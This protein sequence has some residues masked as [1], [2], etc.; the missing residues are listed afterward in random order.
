MT[1]LPLIDTRLLGKPKVYTGAKA[2]WHQWKYVFL[3]YVGAVDQRLLSALELAEQQDSA[4]DFVNFGDTAQQQA[5]TMSYILSQM[6]QG[7]PLQL[8]MNSGHNGLE[9]WRQLVRQEEPVSGASQVATLS[10]ILSTKFSGKGTSFVEEMQKFEGALQRYEAQFNEPLPDALHQA[11]LKSN[12][13]GSIKNQVDMTTF[14]NATVLKDALVQY[15]QV[16]L[17]TAAVHERP[18][19][20]M[21]M[22]VDLV[23]GKGKKNKNKGKGQQKGKYGKGEVK[24][25]GKKGEKG[26]ASSVKFDGNCRNCG[27]YGHRA[28]DCWGAPNRELNEVSG[29]STKKGQA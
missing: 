29:G 7:G 19:D 23:Y 17:A 1:T 11:L 9:A 5:R 25:G 12:A 2:E 14:A 8:V 24:G 26:K 3:A 15:M 20:E 21:A 28:K 4:L 6:L 13:P 18:A 22:E 16:H 27:K 10:L